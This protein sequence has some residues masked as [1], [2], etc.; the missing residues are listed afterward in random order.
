MF[1][2][3]ISVP[4]PVIVATSSVQ[5]FRFIF[6]QGKGHGEI[7]SIPSVI[8]PIPMRIPIVSVGSC[9]IAGSDLWWMLR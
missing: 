1:S 7:R 4:F 2:I 6:Q 5:A 8:I 3:S 9:T